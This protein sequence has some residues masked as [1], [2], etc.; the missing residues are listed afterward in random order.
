MTTTWYST[1]FCGPGTWLLQGFPWGGS[2]SRSQR[3]SVPSGTGGHGGLAPCLPPAMAVG[4]MPWCS[5]TATLLARRSDWLPVVALPQLLPKRWKR[6]L[7]GLLRHT[8]GVLGRHICHSILG[9]AGHVDSHLQAVT[10]NLP[11]VERVTASPSA[12]QAGGL[13]RHRTECPW[14]TPG[15]DQHQGP[16]PTEQALTAALTSDPAPHPAKAMCPGHSTSPISLEQ[17]TQGALFRFYCR[18]GQ[19]TQNWHFSLWVHANAILEQLWSVP[20]ND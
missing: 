8:L 9:K 3:Q 7:P 11:L 10:R 6:E 12:H 17:K 4:T 18:L 1:Q 16:E 20:C 15:P 19:A 14:D 2:C 5:S 13:C